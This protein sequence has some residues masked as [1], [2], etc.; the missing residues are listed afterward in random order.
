MDAAEEDIGAAVISGSDAAAVLEA[1][2]HAL[3]GVSAL[4]EDAAEAGFPAAVGL[5]RDV[6]DGL[7]AL[8]Q[9]AD[10]VAVIRPVGV[11]DAARGQVAQQH[12]RHATVGSLARR[13]VERERSALCV[14]D[15]VKLGVSATPA[16][17]D[18]LGVRP[19]FPPAA[20]R[21]AFTCV[22]SISTSA[23]G[24]PSAA[25]ASNTARQTPFSDQRL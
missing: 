1:T 7:L 8:D 18:R 19:P 12:V 21:C 16:D 23:D 5:G 22:L 3:D 15:R 11:D 17:A 13:Q 6:R 24:P 2:E 14:G 9:I 10:A 20:E 4:V 25:S